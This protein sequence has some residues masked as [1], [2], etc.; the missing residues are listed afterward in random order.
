MRA[1]DTDAETGKKTPG[2]RVMGKLV[3]AKIALI[4]FAVYPHGKWGPLVDQFLFGVRP[5]QQ[6]TIP[7]THPN[8][9][10]M[11]ARA[12]APECPSGIV[13]TASINWQRNHTRPFFSRSYTAPTPREHTI[14]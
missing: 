13:T 11:L 6:N 4:P 14:Q 12:M 7:A 3:D 1:A 8:A 9:A 2:E 10:A 5:R